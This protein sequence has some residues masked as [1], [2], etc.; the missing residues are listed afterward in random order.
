MPQNFDHLSDFYKDIL[1]NWKQ[2]KY[3]NLR[4]LNEIKSQFIWYNS[5]LSQK[6][7]QFWFN[8]SLFQA[9]LLFIGDLFNKRNKIVAFKQWVFRGVSSNSY[10]VWRG[11]GTKLLKNFNIKKEFRLNNGVKQNF[12]GIKLSSKN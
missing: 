8:K 11:L 12:N 6:E 9:G 4:N 10:L 3:K 7:H 5:L 1:Q 2:V